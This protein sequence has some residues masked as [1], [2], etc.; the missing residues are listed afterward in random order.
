MTASFESGVFVYW[1]TSNIVT[2]AQGQ[3]LKNTQVRALLGMPPMMVPL[4]E[5]VTAVKYAAAPAEI[6]VPTKLFA[7]PPGLALADMPAKKQRP[8]GQRKKKRR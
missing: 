1:T 7:R 2:V 3:L 6:V 8:L 5:G 4:P